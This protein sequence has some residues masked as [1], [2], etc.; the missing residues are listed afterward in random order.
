[1][2][3]RDY[4]VNFEKSLSNFSEHSNLLKVLRSEIKEINH[5]ISNEITTNI[6]QVT[7]N[8]ADKIVEDMKKM[9]RKHTNGDEL[10]NMKEAIAKKANQADIEVLYDKKA[11]R[12]ETVSA[13]NSIETIH[14]QIKHVVMMLMESSRAMI[15]TEYSNKQTKINRLNHIVQQCLILTKWI[16]KNNPESSRSVDRIIPDGIKDFQESVSSTLDEIQFSNLKSYQNKQALSKK[17]IRLKT[18]ERTP[19]PNLL[20]LHSGAQTAK[21]K[22]INHFRRRD[23]RSRVKRNS[24]VQGSAK[25][26]KSYK[27]SKKSK[28][29]C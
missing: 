2:T 11:D 20:H 17:M 14:K 26:A 4:E 18:A 7:K 5:R 25:K 3:K 13:Q 6:R 28:C 24:T 1:M 22:L 23:I 16:S 9:L 27:K 12:K 8:E 29:G 19:K 21:A 15:D 10:F